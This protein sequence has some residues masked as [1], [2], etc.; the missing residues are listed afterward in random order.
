[1]TALEITN[2]TKNYK[3][4]LI[5]ALTGVN[6]TISQGN[7]FGLI[8]PNGAG[9]TTL[10]EILAG[11]RKQDQGNIK[12]FGEEITSQAFKYRQKMG[13][14]FDKPLYFEK[15]TGREF[16]K[17]S[18]TMYNLSQKDRK[19]KVD[20]LLDFFD[21]TK[22]A[23]RFIESYSKGMKQKISLAGSIIHEPKLLILD[24]PFDGLDP[25]SSDD[26]EQVLA[27]MSKKEITILIT[28]HALEI[29]ENLCTHCAIINRGSVVFQC[30]M[31]NLNSSIR[32]VLGHQKNGSLRD[33][34]L[35]ITSPDR[36]HKSLSW[37]R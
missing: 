34:F 12:I 5:K 22:V 10:I 16:L 26:I 13:F 31:D 7:I 25:A 35:E 23:D 14:V 9:K 15:F 20:E 3:M 32:N 37:L 21:L 1:M 4:G 6:M 2:L 28:S 11:L 17:F 27:Q 30:Q 24:E 36:P 29:M 18:G 8:G 33:I 19:Y